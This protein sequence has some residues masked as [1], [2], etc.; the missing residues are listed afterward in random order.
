MSPELF[1]VYIHDLSVKLNSLA[2][3]NVPLLN[4]TP[5]THL[6]WADDLV[7]IAKDRSSLQKMLD[8]LKD[9]CTVSSGDLLS[10]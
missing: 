6:F 8:E 10:T 5:I 7:L 3:L 9:Y 4:N 1:K 2:G